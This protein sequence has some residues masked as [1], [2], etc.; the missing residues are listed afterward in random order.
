MWY[1]EM[2]AKLLQ[3]RNKKYIVVANPCK[4]SV[5]PYDSITCFRDGLLKLI[6]KTFVNL[7]GLTDKNSIYRIDEEQLQSH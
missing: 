5:L 3:N 2:S 6:Y 4:L 7:T 1:L